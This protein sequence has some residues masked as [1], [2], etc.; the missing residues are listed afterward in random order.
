[1]A[2]DEQMKNT[3]ELVKPRNGSRYGRERGKITGSRPTAKSRRVLWM[4]SGWCSGQAWWRWWESRRRRS[5]SSSGDC[6]R[7]KM[8]KKGEWEGP[9]ACL[10]IRAD[11]NRRARKSRRPNNNYPTEQMPRISEGIKNERSIV[12]WRHEGFLCFQKMTS[13][14]V[15]KVFRQRMDSD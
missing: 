11:A 2:R 6:E 13:R 10:F 4:N 7:K 5:S 8:R 14:R 12:R 1:M 15:T 9:A 3:E